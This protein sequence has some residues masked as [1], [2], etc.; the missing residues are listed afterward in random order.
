MK[1]AINIQFGILAVVS[2]GFYIYQI[3]CTT[4]SNTSVVFNTIVTMGSIL[5]FLVTAPRKAKP[6]KK[7]TAPADQ[8]SGMYI[9]KYGDELLLCNNDQIITHL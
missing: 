1:K 6:A 7:T 3:F 2:T 9:F 4:P 8:H 5:L